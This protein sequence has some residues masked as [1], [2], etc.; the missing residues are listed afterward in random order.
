MAFTGC[1]L[2]KTPK[3]KTR[4]IKKGIRRI[5]FLDIRLLASIYGL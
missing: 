2:L 3:I 4:A 1:E 5:D